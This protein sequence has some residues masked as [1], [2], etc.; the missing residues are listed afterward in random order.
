MATL[1]AGSPPRT[2]EQAERRFF[3][4]MAFAMALVIVAGFSLNLAM[5]RSTFAVPWIVHV[6]AIIFM[7]FVALYLLQNGLVFSGNLALHRRLGWLSVGWIPAMLVTGF[8]VQRWSLQARGGPFFFDQN[9]FLICNTIALLTFAGLASWAVIIRTNTGWHRRLMFVA[10]AILTGPGL[11]RLLPQPLLI[12]NAWW[13]DQIGVLLFPAI[14][15]LADKKRYGRA[16]PAWL[17]GVGLF[18]GFQIAAN[19]FAYTEAGVG[20]TRWVL[21]GT[22]GA[23][24]PMAAFLPPG[25]AM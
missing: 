6:H 23:E 8:L 13:W 3:M 10:F 24:R 12:P 11:G 22:P 1:H 7:G 16:H 5:G 2:A 21:D 4:V 20:L 15:M 9:Q 18:A 14:G 17:W 25:F 19:S